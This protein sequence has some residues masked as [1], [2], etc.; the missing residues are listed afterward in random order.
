MTRRG[1][2]WYRKYRVEGHLSLVRTSTR[3]GAVAADVESWVDFGA[4]TDYELAQL[5]GQ[6]DNHLE[7][8]NRTKTPFISTYDNYPAAY[9]EALRRKRSGWK[10]VTIIVIDIR[11]AGCRV[12]Y[13]N[14]RKL[15][16][17]LGY[18][19]PDRAWR[20]SEFEYIFLH[21]IPAS[22]IMRV[23]KL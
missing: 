12:E 22:A 2:K 1:V 3:R 20:N 18:R 21:R 10:N 11:E 4:S 19:I 6:L 7:W 5:T 9:E 14:V 16:K 8:R 13:R 23:I 17:K 15:A